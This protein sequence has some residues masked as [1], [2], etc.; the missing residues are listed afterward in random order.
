M[1]Y[2]P[3]TEQ[4]KMYIPFIDLVTCQFLVLPRPA[5]IVPSGVVNA[6][7]APNTSRKTDIDPARVAACTACPVALSTVPVPARYT[8]RPSARPGPRLT[9]SPSPFTCMTHQP[10]GQIVFSEI[11][12]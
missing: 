11:P 2:Y 9:D 4:A 3:R 7:F 1:Q 6:V 12:G 8:L 5:Y 10:G